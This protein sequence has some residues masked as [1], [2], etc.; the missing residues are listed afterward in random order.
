MHRDLKLQNVLLAW[1][2]AGYPLLRLCDL[3]S[4]RAPPTPLADAAARA[5]APG[6]GGTWSDLGVGTPG[7]PFVTALWYR[8]PELLCGSAFSGPPAD[9]WAAAVALCE[10]F[11]LAATLNDA[12]KAAALSAPRGDG[13]P[14]RLRSKTGELKQGDVP[15]RADDDGSLV[16]L[17]H[18]AR[19][20]GVGGVGGGGAAAHP[21]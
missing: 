4:A 12:G 17:F 14:A 8:A 2:P 21:R 6:G 15:A 20:A 19:R 5:P 9:V 13:A 7:T 16:T 11:S 1:S 10:L 18:C 3:G